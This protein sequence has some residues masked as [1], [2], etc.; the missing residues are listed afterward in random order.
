M[1]CNAGAQSHRRRG[2]AGTCGTT[3]R[4]RRSIERSRTTRIPQVFRFLQGRH[5]QPVRRRAPRAVRAQRPAD[6]CSPTHAR[7][8]ARIHLRG[9]TVSRPAARRRSPPPDSAPTTCDAR[10]RAPSPAPARVSRSGRASTSTFRQRPRARRRMPDDV[11]QSVTA[12]FEGGAHGVLLSRVLRDAP[13]Q[14]ARRRTGGPRSQ[15]SID[16]LRTSNSGSRPWA[17]G[18]RIHSARS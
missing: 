15:K 2:S 6:P 14:P 10:R 18:L 12:A 3:T 16:K 4:S 17:S 11:Y 13:G 9:A 8:G 7:T 1:T 5:V